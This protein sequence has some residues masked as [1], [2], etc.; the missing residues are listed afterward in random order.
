M[1][2]GPSTM[3]NYVSIPSLSKVHAEAIQQVSS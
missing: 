1:K 3:S 2:P